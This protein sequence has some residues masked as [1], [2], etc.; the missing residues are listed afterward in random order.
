MKLFHAIFAFSLILSLGG[1][2]NAQ[3]P[4]GGG[5]GGAQMGGGASSRG[6]SYGS[7]GMSGATGNT[8]SGRASSSVVSPQ[9]G[10]GGSG[11][12]AGGGNGPG[13]GQPGGGEM[14][15]FNFG[16]GFSAPGGLS[17]FMNAEGPTNFANQLRGENMPWS[18]FGGFGSQVNNAQ[19]PNN[20]GATI[21]GTP[22]AGQSNQP[23]PGAYSDL[24]QVGGAQQQA[25]DLTTTAAVTSEAEQAQNTAQ[26]TYDDFWS[27]YYS[28]VDEAAETYYE[29]TS[30]YTQEEYEE[31][32]DY[33]T[34]AVDYYE[35]Y[36]DQYEAYCYDNSWDCYSYTYDEETDSYTSTE[37][38]SDDSTSTVEADTSETEAT[39]D[40]SEESSDGEV[41][42]TSAEA[43]EA[44]VVFA[45]DQLGSVVQ[46]MYAGE[47][48]PEIRA[49]FSNESLPVEVQA[50][51]AL[52]S[53]AD[54]AY[55]GVI[56][57]GVAS[58]GVLDCTSGCSGDN[59]P[60]ELST[61]SAGVYLLTVT[62]DMPT[63]SAGDL[64]LITTVYPALNGLAF[65][66]VNTSQGITSYMATAYG[67][68]VD[69]S[70]SSVSVGKVIYAGVYSVDGQT[71]VYS[72][73]AVGDSGMQSF[74]TLLGN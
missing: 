7:P 20:L 3:G 13:G 24:S 59:V 62:A 26:T 17:N 30:D 23:A 16:E 74:F 6:G 50:Y 56:N 51:A 49:L 5:G 36:S 10:N 15:S 41:A 31:A 4:G 25:R 19:Q 52:L 38:T 29:E 63:D 44:I 27:E 58:V 64:E 43:Y 12:G 42:E 2:V 73:V 8:R 65:A 9:G 72:L 37:E 32:V 34:E 22:W 39:W 47:L 69:A 60:A 55:W 35:E 40:E 45:N 11:P 67:I 18:Q 21:N 48:T 1:L 61:S 70:G 68:G 33:A 14:P 71:V 66:E 53:N 54:P 46:P 28:S 57:G